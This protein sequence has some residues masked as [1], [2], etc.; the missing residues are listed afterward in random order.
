LQ[1]LDNNSKQNDSNSNNNNNV[2]DPNT[3][4][5]RSPSSDSIST[6]STTSTSSDQKRRSDASYMDTNGTSPI[7]GPAPGTDPTIIH[8]ITQTMIGEYLWKYTRRNFG[9]GISEK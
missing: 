1:D 2:N 9:A 6:A 7:V 4:H 3:L 8:A 5:Q